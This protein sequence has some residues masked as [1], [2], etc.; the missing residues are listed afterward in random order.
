MSYKILTL[1]KYS[2][3]S[4]DNSH[5]QRIES[6]KL[7]DQISEKQAEQTNERKK[8]LPSV[9][10]FLSDDST[11]AYSEDMKTWTNYETN[12]DLTNLRNNQKTVN[13]VELGAEVQA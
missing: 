13:K 4:K 5:N 3:V 10:L 8:D 1:V 12:L 7:K 9:I 2:S 11:F 6:V